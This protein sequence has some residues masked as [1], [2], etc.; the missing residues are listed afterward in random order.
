MKKT[1]YGIVAILL[2]AS[3]SAF[4][5]TA[6]LLEESNTIRI[7]PSGPVEPQTDKIR[8]EGNVYTFT[9]NINDSIEVERDNIVIDGAEFALKG[10]G[11]K[12][13]RGIYIF[14]R[15]TTSQ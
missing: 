1:V 2:L 5:L 14:Q 9:D 8:W 7:T 12:D 13:S 6:Q 15:R 10:T 3:M 4:A 11:V